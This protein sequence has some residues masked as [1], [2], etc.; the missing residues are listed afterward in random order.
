M[1]QN[2]ISIVHKK[3]TIVY[4]VYIGVEQLFMEDAVTDDQMLIEAILYVA[5]RVQQP[6]VMQVSKLL[7]L[8]DVAHLSKYGRFITG[9]RYVAMRHGPVPSRSYDLM[10]TSNEAFERPDTRSIRPLRDA[11]L[12][13]FSESD[14]ELLDEILRKHGRT[15]ISQLRNICHDEAWK[16]VTENGSAFE[17]NEKPNS[18][19]L[20]IDAI[21]RML[22]NEEQLREHLY[23]EEH[24]I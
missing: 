3:F 15:S 19:P 6:T 18:F 11:D 23:G 24:L 2:L 4:T 12:D 1:A 8:A 13:E 10:K 7:Y 17:N 21:I 22:P 14:L 16:E 20:D 9:D 5:N